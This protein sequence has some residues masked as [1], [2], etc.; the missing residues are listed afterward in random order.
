MLIRALDLVV[1]FQEVRKVH[2]W[3]ANYCGAADKIPVSLDDITT[4][5][6][7]LYGTDL[8]TRLVKINSPLLKGMIEIYE[9]GKAT[10]TVD[11]ELNL[12]D[13]RYV[14]VKEAFHVPLWKIENETKDPG[15]IIEHYVHKLPRENGD[16][17]DVLCEEITKYGAIEILFPPAL[18]KDAKERILRGDATLFTIAEDLR[19]PEH[20]VDF[21][22]ADGYMEISERLRNHN[23][24]NERFGGGQA[25]K[26]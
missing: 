23:P 17:Q 7:D 22:L 4:C 13:T 12:A 26:A 11:A 24:D 10:V 3:L 25:A 8:T 15:L 20:L 9:G 2:A 16:H 5:V 18:R 19:I 14:F 6:K 1:V 21:A